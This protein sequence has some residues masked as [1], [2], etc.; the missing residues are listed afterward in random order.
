MAHV[1]RQIR[2]RVGT[3]LTGLATTAARVY[4]TRTV[5]LPDS[6]L[7]AL[8]IY[9]LSEAS[10]SEHGDTP[11]SQMREL[12]L[13]IEGYA[14]ATADLDDTLDQIAVEVEE[15][16]AAD[17]TLNGLAFETELVAVEILLAKTQGEEGGDRQIG[18]AR[19]IYAVRYQ[20]VE[21]DVET[22]V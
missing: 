11:R 8:C 21:T 4:Q 6:L 1:R 15:A 22:A 18:V 12:R 9:T 3:T 5:S 14:R 17:R 7:P 10:A 13:A 2:E 20:V 19:F 16:M